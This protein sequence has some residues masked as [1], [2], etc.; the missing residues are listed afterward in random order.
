MSENGTVQSSE[1]T[2][3]EDAGRRGV[4]RREFVRVSAAGTVA[5]GLASLFPVNAAQGRSS[6]A[7][8]GLDV[9]DFVRVEIA[10]VLDSDR[11]RSGVILLKDGSDRYLPINVG[12]EQARSIRDGLAGELPPRPMTHDLVQSFLDTIEAAPEFVVV[13][14][15]QEMTFYAYYVF[16]LS[17]KKHAVDSRPSDAIALAVRSETPIFVTRTVM[18]EAS[19]RIE[20]VEG[21]EPGRWA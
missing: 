15:L 13:W 20:N 19:V 5:A 11:S 16:E 10:D 21:Y 3:Q 2:T 17:G 9:S 4:S 1:P 8:V 14:Q 18:N 7:T 6:A 12:E